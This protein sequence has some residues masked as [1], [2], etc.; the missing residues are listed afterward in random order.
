MI[1]W[2]TVFALIVTA[3]CAGVARAELAP[4]GLEVSVRQAPAVVVVEGRR[5]VLFEVHLVNRG[6]QD[7]TP[8]RADIRDADTGAVLAT[9]ADAE[10]AGRLS[11]ITSSS[12][13]DVI[14]PGAE[15][16]I[17]VE[18]DLPE[19]PATPPRGL[20][21]E[22]NYRP[23]ASAGAAATVAQAKPALLTPMS[24]AKLGPPLRGGPWVA[25]YRADWPRGHRRVFYTEGG[26]ARLPG[27]LAIDWV[28]VDDRGR[29]TL[30][31]PDRV[32]DTFGYAADVLAVADGV[33]AA[34]RD[35]IPESP[36]VSQNPAHKPAHAAGNFVA[37]RLPDGR[38][39]IYEHLRPGS[40]RVKAGDA[41]RRG[42]V[43]AQLG[44]TGDS[45]GPHL[46]FHV[47]DAP[48]PLGGEGV[49]YAFAGFS[50]LGRY[51]D[52]GRLGA[53]PSRPL[54]PGLA[55]QRRGEF[56]GSNVVVLFAP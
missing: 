18:L 52:I 9:V 31:D 40:L 23:A 28:R 25:I 55:S 3:S 39:A 42:D 22:I 19:A 30:G 15:A 4:S 6:Q 1:R 27:R 36:R 8:I 14:T 49:G 38:Y 44:F 32:A 43:I 7:V 21:C 11:P 50:L 41:V 13:R 29:T 24:K 45:T 47:A 48:S 16:V 26:R 2:L 5:R 20:A 10:L 17:F 54:G 35:S 12:A 34:A 37:L 46:H 33:V 56:P 53:E 51:D